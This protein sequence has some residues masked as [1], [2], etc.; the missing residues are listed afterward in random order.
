MLQ[1]IIRNI[2]NFALINLIDTQLSLQQLQQIS[3]QVCDFFL[4]V[5]SKLPG[6][7]KS[8]PHHHHHCLMIAE[9]I[10]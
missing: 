10:A 3:N 2:I 4:L 1:A 5:T 8:I 9:L 7:I 6:R